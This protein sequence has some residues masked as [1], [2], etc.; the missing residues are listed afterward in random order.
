MTLR[1]ILKK[2]DFV[3][4][5]YYF[6]IL[7][8]NYFFS[9]IHKIRLFLY[10]PKES[11]MLKD[12]RI[13]IRKIFPLNLNLKNHTRFF[14]GKNIL[15]YPTMS[16]LIKDGK[17]VGWEEGKMII[18]GAEMHIL[19]LSVDREINFPTLFKKHRPEVVVDFGTA[20]GG[21]AVFFYNLVEEYSKPRILSIDITDKDF[22]SANEFHKKNHTLEKVKFL[23]NKSSLDCFEEVKNFLQ[24]GSKEARILLS[25]DDHH[26]YEHT[27]HELQLYSS[28]LK[29]GDIIL[30]QDTW[31]QDLYGHETSPLLSVYRFL[32]ENPDFRLDEDFNKNLVLPCNFI[33]GVLIKR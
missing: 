3:R 31:N 26:T 7:L 9:L 2:N 18:D 8:K 33:Y 15:G 10:F 12:L 14:Q 23:F 20:S 21:T 19:Q 28:L 29:S 17:K 13:E 6:L 30:M 5:S 25:F 32:K 22:Q 11:A 24:E 16:F 27:F 4:K 1:E